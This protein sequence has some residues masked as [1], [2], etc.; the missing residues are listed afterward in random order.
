MKT[1]AITGI[2]GFIG[3]RLRD[4]LLDEGLTVRG[5]DIDDDAVAD[6][7]DAGVDAVVGDVTDRAAVAECVEGADVVV[8][9]AAIVDESGDRDEFYRVNVEGT[10]RVVETSADAGV[11][12]LI[13]LSSVMVHGF[14][15]PQD[16]DETTDFP[17]VDNIYCETKQVSERV[18]LDAHDPE[19][20]DVVVLRPGDVYGAGSRPWVLRPL[21]MMKSGLFKLP[22]GGRGVINHV[23]IDN[24]IDALLL[25]LDEDVGGEVFHITDGVATECLQFFSHHCKMLG[26]GD[27]STAPT[28]LLKSFLTLAGPVCRLSGIESPGTPEAMDFLLRKNRISNAKARDQLGFEPRIDLDEGFR[29]IEQKLRDDGLLE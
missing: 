28:W 26:D 17:D 6:A 9:T 27:V 5:L 7:H 18:A 21:E 10:R 20:M 2:G 1:I 8:H 25:A 24:L 22:G 3:R 29:R 13:H 19:A 16:V 12:R 11:E 23:Y 14:D 15:Y 4:R